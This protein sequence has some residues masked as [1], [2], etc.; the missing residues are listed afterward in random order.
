MDEPARKRRKTSSPIERQRSASPLKKPPRRPSFASPTKASLA[1]NYPNL[2]QRPTTPSS[3]TP[4]QDNRGDILDRGKQARAYILGEA[5]VQQELGQEGSREDDPDQ[6]VAGAQQ[7]RVVRDPNTTPRSRRTKGHGTAGPLL[8]D[9]DEDELD[10]PTTPSQRVIDERDTPR[11]GI[12]FS[13][14]SKRPPRLKEPVK[15]SPLKL[16]VEPVETPGLVEKTGDDEP[17]QKEKQRQPPDP[18]LE[19]RKQEKAQLLSEL[20]NLE[21]D[22]KEC[23]EEIGKLQDRA[24]TNPL[25][26]SERDGIM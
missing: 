5:E 15:Q 19:K 20:E 8:G 24:S 7:S 22:I 17:G 14:P 13:S 18:E 2:L 1:R 16:R 3:A 21:K 26:S 11:R 4:K 12:L 6:A 23:T 25:G 9:A 10:L